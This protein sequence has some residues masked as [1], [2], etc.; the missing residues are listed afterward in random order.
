MGKKNKKTKKKKNDDR[1][2]DKVTMKEA[3]LGIAAMTGSDPPPSDVR[4][5]DPWDEGIVF[6]TSFP[7]SGTVDP[8]NA[9][10]NGYVYYNGV[11]Y[12]AQSN[13]QAVNGYWQLQFSLPV[14][15]MGTC[16][17]KVYIDGGGEPA[18]DVVRFELMPFGDLMEMFKNFSLAAQTAQ[19]SKG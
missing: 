8:L 5:D 3:R 12:P 2:N 17:L 14:G 7:A 18:T 1:D 16:R 9:T 19:A 6:M 10:V 15:S 13:A 11:R 4:I